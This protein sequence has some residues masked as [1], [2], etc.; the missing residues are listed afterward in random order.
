M[1]AE[2]TNSVPPQKQLSN[3][4]NK[5]MYGFFTI[6]SICLLFISKDWMMAV[7]N[8]GIALIF[9]PFDQK[10]TWNDRPLFQKIWLFVH[11]TVVL[12][13]FGYGLFLK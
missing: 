7:G 12:L 3:K 5:Y 9:D 1:V 8:L 2:K 10:I 4:F 13:L 11:V 6:T